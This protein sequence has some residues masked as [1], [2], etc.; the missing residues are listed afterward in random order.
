MTLILFSEIKKWF[1]VSARLLCRHLRFPAHQIYRSLFGTCE[2]FP[3]LVNATCHT[4][5]YL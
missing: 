2:L 3:L 5:F 4:S 1:M